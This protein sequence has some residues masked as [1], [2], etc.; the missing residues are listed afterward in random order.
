MSACYI[1]P[2]GMLYIIAATTGNSKEIFLFNVGWGDILFFLRYGVV[3]GFPMALILGL[4]HY[5]Q[6]RKIAKGKQFDLSPIQNRTLAV[7]STPAV[8]FKHSMFV[9]QKIQARIVE[10]NLAENYI[11]ART[12]TSWWEP[13]GDDI[14]IDV[15]PISNTGT[16]VKITCRPSLKTALVDFGKNYKNAEKLL[17]LISEASPAA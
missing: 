13:W 15:V 7:T 1:I 9:L 14:R 10:C 6:V 5:F 17:S 4:A 2:T 12:R 11:T 3:F 8:I 16:Q